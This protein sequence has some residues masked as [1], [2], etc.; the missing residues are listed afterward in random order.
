MK[1]YVVGSLEPDG[2]AEFEVTFTDPLSD[3]VTLVASYKDADGN[4]YEESVEV[5]IGSAAIQSPNGAG[6]AAPARNGTGALTGTLI[7]VLAVAVVAGC[8]AYAWWN[9]LVHDLRR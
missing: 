4:L 2:L 3:S 6:T 5:N 7:A 8:A 1:S 9:G